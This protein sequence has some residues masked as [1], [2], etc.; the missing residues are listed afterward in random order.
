LRGVYCGRDELELR[1]DVADVV[2]F[3]AAEQGRWVTGQNIGAGGGVCSELWRWFRW[4][5]TAW[6]LRRA[7]YDLDLI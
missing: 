3:L 7:S 4:V 5:D 1:P 2:V 6:L